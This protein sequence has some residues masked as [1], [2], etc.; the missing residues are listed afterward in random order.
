M[1]VR[2]EGHSLDPLNVKVPSWENS[3]MLLMAG[4]TRAPNPLAV[5]HATVNRFLDTRWNCDCTGFTGNHS[6]SWPSIPTKVSLPCPVLHATPTLSPLLNLPLPPTPLP[7]FSGSCSLRPL[8]PVRCHPSSWST[9]S[10][11][12]PEPCPQLCWPPTPSQAFP[13]CLGLSKGLIHPFSLEE[14][15]LDLSLLSARLPSL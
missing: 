6:L 10:Q 1:G 7:P 15:D 9:K 5:K 3:E 11:N 12:R 4:D 2:Q 14:Q 8:C 13:T